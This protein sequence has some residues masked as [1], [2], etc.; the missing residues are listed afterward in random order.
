MKNST[1]KKLPTSLLTEGLNNML[2]E[3][4]IKH[5]ELQDDF[6]CVDIDVTPTDLRFFNSLD[7]LPK[8]PTIISNIDLFSDNL[9]G[10]S[11]KIK[12]GAI[13][14]WGVS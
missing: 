13:I 7:W 4:A 11:C 6:L 2:L 14:E 8:E 12:D 5:G 3:S 10:I 9:S 1:I